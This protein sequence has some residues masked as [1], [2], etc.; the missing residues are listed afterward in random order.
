[1]P[2]MGKEEEKEG[3]SSSSN[4]GKKYL[5]LVRCFRC[6]N[7]GHYASQCLV[8]KKGRGKQQQ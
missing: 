8:K 3:Q 5:C 6:H 2:K 4:H 1:M 7:K